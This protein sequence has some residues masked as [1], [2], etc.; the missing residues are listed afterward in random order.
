MRRLIT[1]TAL[2]TALSIA[3][4]ALA[5][6]APTV[7]AS[8]PTSIGQT[9]ATLQ[10]TVDPNGL[11]A[12]YQFQY[13]STSSLG[14]LAPAT[15]TSAGAGTA[16]VAVSAKIGGLA[17]ATTY[18]YELVATS[19]AGTATTPIGSFTTTGN[20]APTAA[21]ATAANVRRNS[22]TVVG[23]IDPS[24]QATTYYFQYGLGTS[25]GM[26]TAP[27]SLPAG[28]AP[29]PV[30]AVLQGL[31]PGTVFHYRL[32]ASHGTVVSTSGADLT[33]QTLPWPRRRTGLKLSVRARRATP[34]SS[35]VR[36]S[37]AVSLASGT[38]TALGCH[39]VIDVRFF[40]GRHL[41]GT[42]KVLVEPSCGFSAAATVPRSKHERIYVRAS[43]GGNTY[44]A[45][46]RRTAA[47]VLG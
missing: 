47:V 2:L 22:A 40:A 4:L 32:V 7:A 19:S 17:P 23:T 34:T 41:L 15:A 8:G 39:G 14:Q 13:G 38:T 6:S 42:T 29:V 25:Y 3:P 43:F 24:N 18:Y 46:T 9:Y 35:T 44:Q 21:T 10:G 30:T 26:Q 20:P 16:A 27:A 28:T 12:T 37:G 36:T 1:F 33:F 11:A 45:P 31:A 5:A